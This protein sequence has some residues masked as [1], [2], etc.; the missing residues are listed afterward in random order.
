MEPRKYGHHRAIIRD[1]R[2]KSSRQL[3]W[4]PTFNH[5]LS[6]S[7]TPSRPALAIRPGESSITGKRVSFD[8]PGPTN[9]VHVRLT[10]RESPVTIKQVK[11]DRAGT[12]LHD[13]PLSVLLRYPAY[14]GVKTI[15]CSPFQPQSDGQPHRSFITILFF[16][17]HDIYFYCSLIHNNVDALYVS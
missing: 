2:K 12:K 7:R 4:S 9:H 3:P 16:L 5:E 17:I 10:C 15:N 13:V 14:R 6:L 1:F 11:F 8:G